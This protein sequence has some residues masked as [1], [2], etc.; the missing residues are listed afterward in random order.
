VERE[1]RKMAYAL[2]E[3]AKE[4]LTIPNPEELPNVCSSTVTPNPT[5]A[6]LTGALPEVEII[7]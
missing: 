7:K 1:K 6:P 2:T 4:Q 5:S 3:G